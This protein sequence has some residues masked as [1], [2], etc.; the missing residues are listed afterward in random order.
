MMAYSDVLSSDTVHVQCIV[1]VHN[2]CV[3]GTDLAAN[4]VLLSKWQGKFF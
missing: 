4:G 3:Y 1:V 2:K